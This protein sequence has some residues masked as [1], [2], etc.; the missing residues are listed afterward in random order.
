MYKPKIGLIESEIVNRLKNGPNLEKSIT[1]E[2]VDPYSAVFLD[3][4]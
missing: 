3:A 2:S 4:L 1:N